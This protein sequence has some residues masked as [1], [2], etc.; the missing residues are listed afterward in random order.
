[1]IARNLPLELMIEQ[2]AY[3]PLRLLEIRFI[4]D[5]GEIGEDIS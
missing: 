2:R 3:K 4:G 1:M 5:G